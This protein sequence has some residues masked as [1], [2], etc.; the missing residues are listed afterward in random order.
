[1][2]TVEAGGKRARLYFYRYFEKPK[3]ESSRIILIFI[4]KFIWFLSIGSWN[5]KNVLL[6]TVNRASQTGYSFFQTRLLSTD[7]DP[8]TLWYRQEE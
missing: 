3:V 1:M 2:V 5:F 7:R 4:L 6:I 8:N